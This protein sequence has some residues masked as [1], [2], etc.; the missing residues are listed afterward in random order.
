MTEAPVCR[1]KGP[2]RSLLS[3]DQ[4]RGKGNLALQILEGSVDGRCFSLI[5]YAVLRW[6]VSSFHETGPTVNSL[7]V[8]Q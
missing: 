8:D 5:L 6:S 7:Y 1:S 4:P 2:S 3:Q